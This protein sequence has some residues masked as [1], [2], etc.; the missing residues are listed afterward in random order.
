MMHCITMGILELALILL[1]TIVFF[2]LSY[3]SFLRYDAR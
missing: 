1:V 3:V 2:S